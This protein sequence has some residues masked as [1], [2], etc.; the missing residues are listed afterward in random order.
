M[1]GR[2]M[3]GEH[4]KEEKSGETFRVDVVR[5][6]DEYAGLGQAIDDDENG[7]K[8][9]GKGKLL[10][11]I[12][13]DGIPRALGNGQRLKSAVRLVATG[14]IPTTSDARLNISAY[15]SPEVWP[16]VVAGHHGESLVLTGMSGEDMI[17]FIAENTEMEIGGIRD[18]YT[19]LEK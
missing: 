2:T 7:G 4:V 17:V 5:C 13:G 14:F 19:I 1:T 16:V 8:A 9:V 10:D 12:H 3:F 18:V 15:R 11:E 6:R